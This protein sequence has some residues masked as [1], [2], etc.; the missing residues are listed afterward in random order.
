MGLGTS[1]SPHLVSKMRAGI[2]YS[3][4]DGDHGS[5]LSNDSIE[6]V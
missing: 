4:N 6:R 2:S 5:S 3:G 1:N